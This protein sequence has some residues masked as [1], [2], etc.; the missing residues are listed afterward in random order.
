MDDKMASPRACSR[1][2][3]R[4]QGRACRAE[5]ERPWTIRWEVQLAHACARMP[6]RAR[7]QAFACNLL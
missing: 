6:A 1:A 2:P 3:T 5:K 7:P 4:R